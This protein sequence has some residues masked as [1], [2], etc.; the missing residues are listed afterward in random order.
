MGE[1]DRDVAVARQPRRLGGI[2]AA[3]E[4]DFGVRRLR[5]DRGHAARRGNR[6]PGPGQP[7]GAIPGA[8]LPPTG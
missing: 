7:V 4:A 3:G 6:R 5:A 1:D 2:V 8:A